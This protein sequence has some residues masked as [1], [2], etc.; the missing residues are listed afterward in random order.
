MT[1]APYISWLGHGAADLATPGVFTDAKAH[2]FGFDADK[3]AMQTL[4]DALLNPAGAGVVRYAVLAPVALISFMDIA[5]CTSGTDV[6]GWLPG[7]EC[8][9]WVPL[10]EFR[11]GQVLPNR[12][13]LWSPY[14]FISYT[15]GMVT[16]RE[17]WGWPKVL[18]EIS[19]ASDDPG[20]TPQF[21]VKS[22]YFPTMAAET[23][24]VTDTLIRVVRTRNSDRSPGVWTT[25]FEAVEGLVGH[26]LAAL[27][28]A[29]V[30]DLHLHPRLPS[31]ALKQ[32]RNAPDPKQAC[33]QAVVDS[34]IAV[35]KFIDGGPLFDD[36]AL[37]IVTCESH[38]IVRDFLGRAPEPGSTTLPVKFAGWVTMDFQALAGENI[39]IVT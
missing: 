19:V 8:A 5:R 23:R 25:G 16:G 37:E 22:T 24:G 3:A 21:G 12:I 27:A 29:L 17:T 33:Y 32:F 7:R 2:M 20:G 14:I 11:H 4:V 31:V 39:A 28:E 36:F 10:L 13:V 30:D 35:T 1:V 18:A 15:I 26:V 38:Q 6:V 34:P 9:L